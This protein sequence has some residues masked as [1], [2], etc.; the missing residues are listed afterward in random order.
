MVLKSRKGFSKKRGLQKLRVKGLE[1]AYRSK[2]AKRPLEEWDSNK[3]GL[4]QCRGRRNKDEGVKTAQGHQ[5][6]R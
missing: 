2:Y 3:M 4:G 1:M 6:R 5:A